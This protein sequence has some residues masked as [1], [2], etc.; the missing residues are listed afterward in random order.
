MYDEAGAQWVGSRGGDEQRGQETLVWI[1][2]CRGEMVSE[3]TLTVMCPCLV[4]VWRMAKVWG[5][6]ETRQEWQA[7][8]E[9]QGFESGTFWRPT[10]P[11]LLLDWMWGMRRRR[12]KGTQIFL[13][14]PLKEWDGQG[15]KDKQFC[16]RD[17]V[18][19]PSGH[20][21]GGL[22]SQLD[23]CVLSSREKYRLK[24]KIGESC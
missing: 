17:E 12:V 21:S 23:T 24:M 10:Q 7:W 5:D 3:E 18:S 4:S 8:A 15:N 16:F 2:R 14:E 20:S 13:S 6:R 11:I 9:A 1:L 19:M 22:G